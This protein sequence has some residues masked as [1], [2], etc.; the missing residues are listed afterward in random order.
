ML[1]RLRFS[2]AE[3]AIPAGNRRGRRFLEQRGWQFEQPA[4]RSPM[5]IVLYG[6]DLDGDI[7]ENRSQY[8]A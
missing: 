4:R 5:A 8:A 3:V 2:R 7:S 1:A 6:R